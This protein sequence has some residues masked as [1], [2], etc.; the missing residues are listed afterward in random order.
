MP[1]VSSTDFP[2]RMELLHFEAG[3]AVVKPAGTNYQVKLAVPAE[4]SY[5]ATGRAYG[6]VRA[7][8]RKLWTVTSGGN[9][10]API[11]GPPRIVQ[12]RVRYLDATSMVVGC[13]FPVIVTLP[14]SDS[15]F[16]LAGGALAVGA[17]VNVTLLPGATF[18]AVAAPAPVSA[19]FVPVTGTAASA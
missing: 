3:A 17:L 19:A 6:L 16:D 11:F 10:V 13:G 15:A 5:P 1:T 14:A 12:G 4:F 2:A 9:F 7:T 8:A 18:E